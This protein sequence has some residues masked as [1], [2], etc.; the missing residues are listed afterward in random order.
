MIK[1]LHFVRRFF[2]LFLCQVVIITVIF[3]IIFI[4]SKQAVEKVHFPQQFSLQDRFF[5]NGV[6]EGE[7]S[8]NQKVYSSKTFEN[9][10]WNK[11]KSLILTA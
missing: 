1:I 3:I 9:E 6:L 4:I 8:S 11:S 7:R 5:K 10:T 2:G